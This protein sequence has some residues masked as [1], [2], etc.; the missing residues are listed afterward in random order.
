MYD[1]NST[2]FL[3][4]KHLY[5]FTNLSIYVGKKL[6]KTEKEKDYENVKK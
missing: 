4:Q 5:I 1:Y 2:I 3:I 6:K